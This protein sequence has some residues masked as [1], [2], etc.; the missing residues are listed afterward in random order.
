MNECEIHLA[1]TGRDDHQANGFIEVAV[2]ELK[3]QVRALLSEVQSNLR[4]DISVTHPSLMWIR[5]HAAFL[6]TRFRVGPDGKTA[7][8]RTFGR[9]WRTPMIRFGEH[10][11]YRPKANQDG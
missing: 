7:C 2:R 10:V 8:E 1:E 9:S 11:L 4:F 6:L 3:R 5:R